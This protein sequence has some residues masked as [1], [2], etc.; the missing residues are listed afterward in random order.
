MTPTSKTRT[1]AR[2]LGGLATAVLIAGCSDSGTRPSPPSATPPGA[3]VTG[4]TP[5]GNRGT[6]DY[7]DGTY[8]A[9]GTYGGQPSETPVTLTLRDDVITDV[10][11]GTPATDPT[12]L[13][14]QRAFAEAVPQAVVGRDI[15]DV[16]VNRL[17]GASGCS[18]GFTDA[19]DQ[20]KQQAG[21]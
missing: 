2:V 6:G 7:A 11:V 15:D 17:A 4:S 12:S 20:I 5:G 3:T 1:A 16:Q 14:Y 9:T 21:R 8:R 10:Q 18:V 19:L 13:R